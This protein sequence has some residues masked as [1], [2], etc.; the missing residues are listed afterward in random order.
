MRVFQLIAFVSLAA[1]GGSAAQRPAPAL[2]AAPAPVPTL[3]SALVPRDEAPP[4]P[5]KVVAPPAAEPQIPTECANSD[6]SPCVPPAEFV[7]SLC[8]GF[9]RQD[10]ALALFAKT[11]PFTRLYLRGKF[12]ELA[13]DEEVLALS[14]S[15]S[16]G[17]IVG[18][19][20]Y[21]VL[22]WDGTCSRGVD[23]DMLTQKRPPKPRTARLHWSHLNEPLQ[24]SLIRSSPR[25]K[26]AHAKQGKECMG[27]TFFLS[28]PACSKADSDL[29]DSITDYVRGGGHSR[30]SSLQVA[31][32]GGA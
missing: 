21:D 32:R 18:N 27:S 16:N 22:R 20:T 10:L 24:I 12:E 5:I 17:I 4:T 1:C 14:R 3:D 30:P 7:R 9:S 26:A 25:I 23:A 31:S 2:R 13:F 28:N 11:T 8:D 6:D 15:S 19:G 29:T